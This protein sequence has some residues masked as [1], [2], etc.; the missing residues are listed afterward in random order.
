M[1]VLFLPH[2]LCCAEVDDA[3]QARVVIEWE[4]FCFFASV[5]GPEQRPTPIL[6]FNTFLL[7]FLQV[8]SVDRYEIMGIL[9]YNPQD[10]QE[11]VS[12]KSGS[13]L[14]SADR[15]VAKPPTAR[16]SSLDSGLG[17]DT[18]RSHSPLTPRSSSPTA[19]AVSPVEVGDREKAKLMARLR[20]HY[21]Q[22]DGPAPEPPRDILAAIYKNVSAIAPDD[23]ES[24]LQWVDAGLLFELT[25]LLCKHADSGAEPE[26]PVKI[27][28]RL[29]RNNPE[30][31]VELC[32]VMLVHLRKH[33]DC[34]RV[35][36]LVE[37]LIK[38]HSFRKVFLENRG[39]HI[40]LDFYER[41]LVILHG[42]QYDRT[43][44]FP[45]DPQA[46]ESVDALLSPSAAAAAS[47]DKS[48][49]EYPPSKLSQE[50]TSRT[51]SPE[52][53]RRLGMLEKMSSDGAGVSTNSETADEE[54][55][56]ASETQQLAASE[57]QHLTAAAGGGVSA[58]SSVQRAQ[59]PRTHKRNLEKAIVLLEAQRS[60]FPGGESAANAALAEVRTELSMLEYSMKRKEEIAKLRDMI[61]SMQGMGV[62]PNTI[63]GAV[64]PL[65]DRLAVLCEADKA[66]EAAAKRR[67]GASSSSSGSSTSGEGSTS[68]ED[69]DET[70]THSSTS[71]DDE[72]TAPKTP[73]PATG[74]ANSRSPLRPGLKPLSLRLPAGASLSPRGESDLPPPITPKTP[75]VIPG[76]SLAAKGLTSRGGGGRGGSGGSGSPTSPG[77]SGS[78]I[79]TG[80]ARS[81][82]SGDSSG[83][84]LKRGSLLTSQRPSDSLTE[85]DFRDSAALRQT[86]KETAHQR[87]TAL[88]I[89]L[90]ETFMASDLTALLQ[91]KKQAA[92]PMRDKGL[93]TRVELEEQ[94]PVNKHIVEFRKSKGYT[95][96]MAILHVLALLAAEPCA[97]EFF[98]PPINLL[99]SELCASHKDRFLRSDDD[100][101]LRIFSVLAPYAIKVETVHKVQW[102]EVVERLPSLSAKFAF[103]SK[104]D[105]FLFRINEQLSAARGLR[106]PADHRAVQAYTTMLVDYLRHCYTRVVVA[107]V[108]DVCAEVML[109]IARH[110]FDANVDLVNAGP[111]VLRTV[112]HVLHFFDE[113]ALVAY[114]PA[115]T[116]LL[117]SLFIENDQ[118]WLFTR[119]LSG[120]LFLNSKLCTALKDHP[121]AGRDFLKQLRL[122][123]LGHLRACVTLVERHYREA[124]AWRQQG[125]VKPSSLTTLVDNSLLVRL[126]L[127]KF[128]FLV[129]P[130]AGLIP[131]FFDGHRS[132]YDQYHVKMEMLRLLVEL[133]GFPESPL[134]T[135]S[136]KYIDFYISD[137]Y[138][139]FIKLFN[140]NDFDEATLQMCRLY[141]EVLIRFSRIKES[142][143]RMKMSQLRVMD[144]LANQIDL[145]YQMTLL[146]DASASQAPEKYATLSAVTENIAMRRSPRPERRNA[147]TEAPPNLPLARAVDSSA[148]PPPALAIS[149]SSVVRA[150]ATTTAATATAVVAAGGA[151]DAAANG[152]ESAAPSHRASSRMASSRLVEVKS[153]TSRSSS[154]RSSSRSASSS[155]SASASSSS[156]GSSSGSDSQSDGESGDSKRVV[157][158]PMGVK[159]IPRTP[160]AGAGSSPASASAVTVSKPPIA[161]RMGGGGLALPS[162]AS[163]VSMPTIIVSP[164]RIKSPGRSMGASAP[165]KVSL[166][167]APG[168]LA[169][170]AA[171]SA[172]PDDCKEGVSADDEPERSSSSGSSS[173][174]SSSE[175]DEAPP[176]RA[177][178]MGVI[179]IPRVKAAAAAPE[180][181]APP[182]P[183]LSIAPPLSSS[184][185]LVAKSPSQARRS[186][187]PSVVVPASTTPS[188]TLRFG[189]G[190]VQ[191]WDVKDDDSKAKDGA[192][193]SASSG[194]E[195]ESDHKDESVSSSESSAENTPQTPKQAMSVKRIPRADAASASPLRM[196]PARSPSMSTPSSPS[197]GRSTPQFGLRLTPSITKDGSYRG[198]SA[199]AAASGDRSSGS[200]APA[201][202]TSSPQTPKRPTTPLGGSV[203]GMPMA[204]LRLTPNLT[205]DGSASSAALASSPVS[206]SPQQGLLSSSP[207][208][209]PSHD[210]TG[211]PPREQLS[212]RYETH[213]ASSRP[214]AHFSTVA[215]RRPN[216]RA[217]IELGSLFAMSPAPARPLLS[218]SV[219]DWD[220]DG[221]VG[222][223]FT[224][225]DLYGD[226]I[227]LHG[228]ERTKIKAF[229]RLF[230]SPL[231]G[232][233]N[234]PVKSKIEPVRWLRVKTKELLAAIAKVPDAAQLQGSKVVFNPMGLPGGKRADGESSSSTSDD[235]A[236]LK[237]P[238]RLKLASPRGTSSP[239][240][241][242]AA[243]LTPRKFGRPA[244]GVSKVP[245]LKVPTKDDS[246]ASSPKSRQPSAGSE[247]KKDGLSALQA[248]MHNTDGPRMELLT[249]EQAEQKKK[250]DTAALYVRNEE[251]ERRRGDSKL[252]ALTDLHLSIL[253]LLLD[254]MI[255]DI[256]VLDPL[257]V[258]QFPVTDKKLNI[259]FYL[260]L[261][262]N[263]PANRAVI[264]ELA[265]RLHELGTPQYRLLKLL[266]TQ[267]FQVR[268]G[269][270]C[271]CSWSHAA[272]FSLF[273]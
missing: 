23:K 52:L 35:Y 190:K 13:T 63:K 203:K 151:A 158:P 101:R 17:A 106:S 137:S 156:S 113:L 164:G 214:T 187:I 225:R 235:E 240:L 247:K 169:V 218:E 198:T 226:M 76:L 150:T 213:K 246:T 25:L 53:D 78:P 193:A 179:R 104:L 269:A 263:H 110:L 251:Y 202:A 256:G 124:A 163:P 122:R 141:I 208:T 258:S 11:A 206:S 108:M 127:T 34:V 227:G 147:I 195:E 24:R 234:E 171:T 149:T 139:S 219:D 119:H 68:G 82:V 222:G 92:P 257:Y 200:T 128:E 265:S 26:E 125:H 168:R 87:L 55:S 167:P 192:S 117:V 42:R 1:C 166:P 105:V 157:P 91:L 238:G 143:V 273:S 16:G 29:I 253:T 72:G 74:S 136:L 56:L 51:A 232:E 194:D 165:P 7:E 129:M 196:S 236:D 38:M 45:N 264:P 224:S 48:E 67:L 255:N 237:S 3:L 131:Q 66:A 97:N 188:F 217:G 244:F 197:L 266:S 170:P 172:P 61:A 182:P 132:P 184:G 250:L 254:L 260:R 181:S 221:G 50:G 243:S 2:R 71:D 47:E 185:T 135:R 216:S 90:G 10:M 54:S 41:T 57:M 210:M 80:S 212:A 77:D 111:D 191:E 49:K 12:K 242:G 15:Y 100:F 230:A 36:Q 86:S 83:S 84:F 28:K 120:E 93:Q 44:D 112:M 183:A 98:D 85:T 173:A 259:P 159:R 96:K 102:P 248:K 220:E 162:T 215:A 199:A 271:L 140:S 154:S 21:H 121:T 114:S 233:K 186:G 60:T 201:S 19:Q 160:A 33:F 223:A 4:Q 62:D 205:K 267:L 146:A 123:V 39:A 138:L 153:S 115:I 37:N 5:N 6:D 174:S 231:W 229:T 70:S 116:E 69:E 134:V 207:A 211:A 31:S 75:S 107:N 59:S 252:Y 65:E 204:A 177:P 73:E 178:P 152:E 88:A 189:A 268:S 58:P 145:E 22:K 126:M 161:M 262:L 18:I 32:R 46:E 261:H 241:G 27:I 133:F 148:A 30:A 64:K 209:P 239:A 144:F 8:R 9:G 79:W 109:T 89:K 175:T 130:G 142:S 180:K 249:K 94:K 40:L 103:R 14:K 176:S 270:A 155:S 245:E 95:I 43:L 228:L 81:N 118:F 272:L 20:Y 99:L